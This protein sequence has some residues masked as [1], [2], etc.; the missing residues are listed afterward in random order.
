MEIHTGAYLPAF[1]R[2]IEEAGREER[3]AFLNLISHLENHEAVPHLEYLIFE[4]A[5]DVSA[6]RRSAEILEQM[7]R[8]LE[9]GMAESLK[10]AAQI[11]EGAPA[12][13]PESIHG[14]NPLFVKFVQLPP[15]LR[16]AALTELAS[17]AP[18]MTLD[19]IELLRSR[20]NLPPPET[21]E[22]LVILEDPRAV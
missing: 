2:R 3:L 5:V 8:P 19:F 21:V 20:E 14:S 12:L 6:K 18:G 22:A 4:A 9:V 10:N 17:V 13:K 16:Q 11:I 7:G 1:V 15:T